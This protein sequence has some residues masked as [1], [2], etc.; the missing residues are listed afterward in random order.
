MDSQ[1]TEAGDRT[2]SALSGRWLRDNVAILSAASGILGALVYALLTILASVVYEPL[3]VAPDEVGLG[4]STLLLRAAV[5]VLSVVALAV[6]TYFSIALMGL[7]E[8]PRSVI[9]ISPKRPDL[10]TR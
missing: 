10:R 1:V 5:T 9:R 8:R 7:A 6:L 2:P 3:R 4:Y